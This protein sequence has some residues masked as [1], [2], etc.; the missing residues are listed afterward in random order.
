MQVQILGNG[1]GGPFQGR[2]YSAQILR[3]DQHV[4]LIDC[5]EGTQMQLFRYRVRYDQVRQIFISHLHGDH[6]YGLAGLITSFCLKRRTE[7]LEVFSPPGLQELIETTFRITG[8]VPPFELVFHACWPGAPALVFENTRVE[9]W[10][11]S[12]EHRTPCTGWLFREK[13][14]LRNIRKDSIQEFQIPYALIPGIKA[15]ADLTLSDGTR[16]PNEVLTL[17]PGKPRSYAY[18]SD[19]AY[20]E[21]V[22]EAVRGVDLLYHE[23]TFTA[24]HAAEAVVAYHSTAG[25]AARIAQQAG[26]GQLLLGHFSSRYAGLDQ[27]LLEARAVFGATLLAEEGGIY[28]VA[29][30]RRRPQ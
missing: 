3:L 9:V 27:H 13:P 7:R 29:E 14:R 12:L 8:V 4:F 24:E 11:F 21:A 23:A 2:H 5:G 1:A 17:S 30:D 15:G 10:S 22:V 26:A 18:C 25:D 28:P 6:V 19:T 16:V 20:S